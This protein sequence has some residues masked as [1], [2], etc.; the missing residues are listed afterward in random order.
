MCAHWR[1]PSRHSNLAI[2]V[3]EIMFDKNLS[4]CLPCSCFPDPFE[5]WNSGFPSPIDKHVKSRTEFTKS[6]DNAQIKNHEAIPTR[7]IFSIIS[8]SLSGVRQSSSWKRTSCRS[9]HKQLESILQI[10]S[11]CTACIRSLSPVKN[12]LLILT[13]KF[14][15]RC[16][17][18]PIR[19]ISDDDIDRF[20]SNAARAKGDALPKGGRATG[21]GRS[22][23]VQFRA[24]ERKT[25]SA[26]TVNCHLPARVP[27]GSQSVPGRTWS[28]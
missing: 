16:M 2:R 23:S 27:D 6:G 18:P 14:L 3:W 1:L 22:F 10:L 15:L 11:S 25:G 28:R 12:S 19:N 9:C 4:I 24:K 8:L 13:G 5:D 21:K 26:P 20:L 17:C 7:G